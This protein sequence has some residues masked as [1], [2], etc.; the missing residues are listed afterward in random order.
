MQDEN[1]QWYVA[2]PVYQFVEFGAYR[3]AIKALASTAVFQRLRRIS[4]LGLASYVFPGAVH[5]R[6]A[7]SLGAAHLAARLV[8]QLPIE[9][10]DARTVVCAALLHDIGHGPFSHSFERALKRVFTNRPK[11]EDWTRKIVLE[12]LAGILGDHGIDAQRVCSLV[13]PASDDSPVPSFVR[14]IISSQLD[15][16]RMDYLCRDAHFTGVS[17]GKVDVPYLLRNVRVV[18][19]GSQQTLGLASKG[20]QC[21]EAF[22]FARHTMNKTVYFHQRVATFECMMEECIRLLVESSGTSYK[23]DLIGVLR[24]AKNAK[25]EEAQTLLFEPYL[26]AT[27]AQFWTAVAAA[28]DRPDQLGRLASMLLERKSV[29]S[30]AVVEHMHELLDKELLSAGFQAHQY[31][32]RSLPTGIYKQDSGEQVFVCDGAGEPPEHIS[33]RS[34]L[35]AAFRDQTDTEAVLVI[36]DEAARSKILDVAI[37]AHCV[38]PDAMKSRPRPPTK[39][40]SDSVPAEPSLKSGT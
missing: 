3:R 29:P 13:A 4:Q 17:V 37:Q 6:F 18:E 30:T 34:A 20:V 21:Y 5:S 36:F 40:R 1:K 39:I 33:R 24:E 16:D 27:E 22:A 38:H 28:A 2:D 14:Q 15:V 31:C 11:H 25:P 12:S 35:V 32:V 8:P 19:H 10:H 23:P 9:Q 26:K 7:H